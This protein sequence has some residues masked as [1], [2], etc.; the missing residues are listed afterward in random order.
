MPGER[1]GRHAAF[2]RCDD[3]A[4]AIPKTIAKLKRLSYLDLSRT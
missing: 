4:T 3:T 1:G 2:A